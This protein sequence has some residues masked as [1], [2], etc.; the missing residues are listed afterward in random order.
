[1]PGIQISDG[2]KDIIDHHVTEGAAA[3]ETDFVEA[4]VRRYAEYLEDDENALITA[5]EKG[6]ATIERGDYVTISG[7][8]D[9]AALRDR[10]WERAM[11][12]AEEMRAA[13]TDL[14]DEVRTEAQAGE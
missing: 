2:V 9:V 7:P 12:L 4:A 14:C 11:V 8:D 3:S 10:V 1:M 13:G 5:A 6:I